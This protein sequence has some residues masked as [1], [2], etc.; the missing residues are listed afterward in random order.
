MQG[1]MDIRFKEQE[2]LHQQHPPLQIRMGGEEVSL[3]RGIP[4]ALLAVAVG[5]LFLLV[6]PLSLEKISMM[7]CSPV[8]A[9]RIEN[10]RVKLVLANVYANMDSLQQKMESATVGIDRHAR[11]SR[12]AMLR[13][14]CNV[15]MAGNIIFRFGSNESTLLSASIFSEAVIWSI[16]LL[17]K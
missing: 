5:V 2:P 13:M 14:I 10:L 7:Y 8:V 15:L 12:F 16:V 6:V 1:V 11:M 9:I 3:S 17:I 4:E